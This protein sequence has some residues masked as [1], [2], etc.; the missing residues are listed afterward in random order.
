MNEDNTPYTTQYFKKNID[1]IKYDDVVLG[2]DVG[3]TTTNIAIA[4]IKKNVVDLLFSLDFETKKLPSFHQALQKTI[5]FAKE[6]Y[7]LH[8]K[9]GCIG[10]AGIVSD[11]HSFVELTNIS[12]NIDTKDLIQKTS[13][14]SLYIFN[15]FQILGYGLNV[16]DISDETAVICIRKAENTKMKNQRMVLIGAGT[17]LGKSMLMYDEKNQLYHAFE[18][19]GGHADIPIYTPTELELITSIQ[20][21]KHVQHPVSY[22]DVLSG[23]GLVDIYMFL[24]SKNMF[25]HSEYTKLI[26][27]AKDKPPLISKYHLKDEYCNETFRLFRRFLARCAKNLA[28]DT[29]SHGG[30]FI[31]GGIAVK[32]KEIVLSNEFKTEFNQSY[33]QSEFLKKIPLY[34]VSNYYLSLQGACFVASH[35]EVILNNQKNRWK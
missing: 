13:M 20:Q 34:L 1:T 22:E 2:A 14:N 24:R 17:G 9:K 10:A 12:W 26:D 21:K 30:V 15:D 31:A 19:E 16:V 28:L 11:D 8:L 7:N 29:L 6:E 4:G 23:T 18:S 25:D 27:E 33:I 35:A 32:N 5:D 3:G